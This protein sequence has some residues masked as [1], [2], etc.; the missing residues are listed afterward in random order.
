[1]SGGIAIADVDGDGRGDLLVSAL[2]ASSATANGFRYYRRRYRWA[3]LMWRT[4]DNPLRQHQ[5]IA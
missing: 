4:N 3:E 1:M 5:V 2:L